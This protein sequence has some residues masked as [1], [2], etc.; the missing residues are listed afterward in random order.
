MAT[1]P[2]PLFSVGSEAEWARI[3]EEEERQ[4]AEFAAS[5]SMA[6]RVAYGQKLSQQAMSL[7]A[8][9]VRAGHVSRRALWS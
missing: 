8:A 7:F 9:S 2:K 1:N 5:L 6:E 3:N 4:E